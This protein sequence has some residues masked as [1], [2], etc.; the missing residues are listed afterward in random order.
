MVQ[1]IEFNEDSVSSTVT[2]QT[3]ILQTS[4]ESLHYEQQ[5]IN[6]L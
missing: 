1:V 3:I 6:I 4:S 5:Q 2:N